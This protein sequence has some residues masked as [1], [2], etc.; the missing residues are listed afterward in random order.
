MSKNT[1][2]SNESLSREQ[3]RWIQSLDLTYSVKN[4]KR[5]FSNGFLIAEIFSRYYDKEVQMHS[6]DNGIAAR[7]KKDNWQQLMKFMRKVG[8]GDLATQDDIDAIIHC[9][10]MAVVKFINRAYEKLTK[11]KVQE[12]TRRPI[13]VA[14]PAYAKNTGSTVLRNSMMSS[15]LREIDD[16]TVRKARMKEK[17]NEHENSLQSERSVDPERFSTYSQNLKKNGQPRSNMGN[18]G[19]PVPMVT[20]KEISV[21]QVNRNIAQL[22]ANKMGLKPVSDASLNGDSLLAPILPPLQN[23]SSTQSHSQ[24]N[25]PRDDVKF[26]GNAVDAMSLLNA[27][28]S[29]RLGNRVVASSDPVQVFVQSIENAEEGHDAGILQV[30]GEV[31]ATMPKVAQ[32]CTG[33]P[34]DFW[35][36]SNAMLGLVTVLK[37]GDTFDA[38]LR[39]T[40]TFAEQVIQ[41]DTPNAVR[42]FGDF[43]LPKLLPLF[44]SCSRKRKAVMQLLYAFSPP[45]ATSHYQVL[46]RLQADLRSMPLFIEAVA[47]AIFLETDFTDTS[48]DMYTYYCKMG[49]TQSSP[50]LRA[51]A[52]AM[53]SVLLPRMPQ[54]APLKLLPQLKQLSAS[55][56]WPSMRVSLVMVA[57]ALLDVNDAR[58]TEEAR[59]IVDKHFRPNAAFVVLKAGI[60]TLAKF[61]RTAPDLLVTMCAAMLEMPSPVRCILVDL[62]DH[63]KEE[64]S[65]PT[66]LVDD[67]LP[68]TPILHDMEALALA[69]VLRDQVLAERL[70]S[71]EVGHMQ[72]LTATVLAHCAN[73]NLDQEW[74]Q[75]FDELK[76]YVF[77]ALCDPEECA[78]AASVIESFSFRSSLRDGMLREAQLL[79][80]LRLIFAPGGD[81]TCQAQ[82]VRMLRNLAA[83]GQKF[84]EAVKELLSKVVGSVDGTPLAVL[85]ADMSH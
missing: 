31:E 71:L 77:V 12:V 56:T 59:A 27:C 49:M 15:K 10:D 38:I 1:L 23:P 39:A 42:L 19:A 70:E 48:V 29:R 58:V 41:A 4:I 47:L 85:I 50:R 40:F 33:N 46:K 5:D 35:Q 16:E 73:S 8:F 60:I 6:Y 82:Y 53:L 24:S 67:P 72:I 44:Q 34:K 30:I 65:S 11:R 74:I 55:D 78:L 13:P 62:P 79:G 22:R 66:A 84:R 18:G 26:Q 75:L 63:L 54:D 83:E 37:I 80:V 32:K 52:V 28:V 61:T 68:L 20:V 64:G 3:L 69:K 21:K 36:V 81:E 2:A 51:A 17:M 43:T 7:I 25:T 76:D 9:E 14:K 45:D 57:A